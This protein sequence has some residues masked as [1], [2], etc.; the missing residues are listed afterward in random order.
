VRH[1]LSDRVVPRR[2][3]VLRD[4]LESITVWAREHQRVLIVVFCGVLGTYLVASG[5]VG[6]LDSS[7]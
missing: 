7:A 5:V 6:L 1:P 4:L 3:A 2:R